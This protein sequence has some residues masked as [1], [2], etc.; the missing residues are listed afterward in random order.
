MKKFLLF[1]LGFILSG[2]WLSAQEE[3]P[4]FTVEAS[5]DSILM[6]NYFKVVFTLENASGDN[7]EPPV[8]QG[9]DVASGPSF[10]SSISIFNGRTSQ[11]VS[12]TYYLQPRDIGNYYIEPASIAVGGKVLETLP[13]EVIVVPNPDG[14]IQE[15]G[16]PEERLLEGF[17]DWDWPGS[18]PFFEPQSPEQQQ[19]APRPA[20]APKKKRKTYKL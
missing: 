7:F 6:G 17:G 11:K 15:P 18:S 1:S 2:G 3:G 16:Q 13:V 10:A 5:S 4:R 12:Y 9:F 20:P 14:I 19:P 8:F